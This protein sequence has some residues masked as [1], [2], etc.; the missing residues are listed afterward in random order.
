MQCGTRTAIGVFIYTG[1][2]A[3]I[4]VAAI[5]QSCEAGRST[6]AANRAWLGPMQLHLLQ[7]IESLPSRMQLH[8]INFGR[9][10][11][12]G[13]VWKMTPTLAPYLED[14]AR[15]ASDE[16]KMGVKNSACDGLHPSDGDGLVIYPLQPYDLPEPITDSAE[17]REIRNKVLAK[18]GTLLVQGCLGYVTYGKPHFSKF[19]FFLRDVA[20]RPSNEWPFNAPP[21]G[22]HAD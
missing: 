15:D 18:T 10:P 13:V 2:T 16:K 9:E 4:T 1:L 11:A 6:D 20:G 7:P 19:E 3:I 22:N 12:N 5:L 21:E 14:D 17:N 8:V